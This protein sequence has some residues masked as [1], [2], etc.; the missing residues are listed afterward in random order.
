[1]QHEEKE[2][3]YILQ[4]NNKKLLHSSLLYHRQK[5]HLEK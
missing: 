2:K 3:N 1:M 4:Y 5:C